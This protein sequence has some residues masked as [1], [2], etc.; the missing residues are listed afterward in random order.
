[1]AWNHSSLRH[2]TP[3]DYIWEGIN[4]WLDTNMGKRWL[5][6]VREEG[7]ILQCLYTQNTD[8]EH[9]EDKCKHDHNEIISVL[10]AAAGKSGYSLKEVRPRNGGY[11]ERTI[12]ASTDPDIK[13]AYFSSEK[14]VKM[15]KKITPKGVES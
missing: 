12:I 5:K 3:E 10:A 14:M 15:L 4:I 1:M 13:L 9:V 8:E 6:R 7:I 2:S 11:E